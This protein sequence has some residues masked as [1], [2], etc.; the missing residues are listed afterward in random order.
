MVDVAGEFLMNI[1]RTMRSYSD[2]FAQEMSVE[3]LILHALFENGGIDVRS[4]ESYVADDVV[5]YGNKMSDLLRKLRAS[6][7]DTLANTD[8][9]MADEAAYFG[10]TTNGMENGASQPMANGTM[11]GE[12]DENILRGGYAAGL[13]EDF[14]GFKDMGLDEEL[15]IDV[16]RQLAA[17]PSRVFARKDQ[18]DINGPGGMGAKNRLGGSGSSGASS[19]DFDP[20]SPFVPLTEAAISAQIELL[21]PFY[22]EELRSRGQWQRAT[23]DQDRDENEGIHPNAIEG[24]EES[25]ENKNEKDAYLILPDEDQERQRYKVPPTGKLPRRAMK[26]RAT[27]SANKNSSQKISK[28]NGGEGGTNNNANGNLRKPT[29]STNNSFGK[30][31]ATPAMN[32][33]GTTSKSSTKSKS[34]KKDSSSHQNGK[35]HH[36]IPTVTVS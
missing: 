10:S 22:R 15:G 5:R 4:L 11:A 12:E 24:G 31:S 30:P 34:K 3:E 32:L 23:Q 20:P 1:G 6:Y 9:T 19:L 33:N 28:L 2:R 13:D 29:L 7:K 16:G 18:D 21:R 26:E 14:F 17:M 36:S 8:L 35:Q 27:Q 25:A